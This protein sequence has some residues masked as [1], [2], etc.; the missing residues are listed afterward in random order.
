MSPAWGD[1]RAVV[2]DIDGTL[3]DSADG[4][5]AGYVHALESVGVT[6]PDDDTL[7]SDL[8]PPI[9][10]LLPSL[11]VPAERLDEA[12]TAYRTF[13]LREGLQRAAEYDGVSQVL[14]SLS[15]AFP[16]GTATAKRTDVALAIL[17]SHGL[18]GFFTVVN[19]L[20]DDHPTKA[21]TLTQTL[22]L[23]GELDPATTVMVGDRRSDIVAGRAVG[24]WTI[25]VLWGYGSRA[26][27]EGAGADVLLEHPHQLVDLLLS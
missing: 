18:A 15:R 26:E 16:L 24:T 1:L 3:L 11:G 22:G 25:G 9:V 8:G 14:T 7:R 17:E 13:Y 21:A 27:L 23:M 20:G 5:V 19:G 12:L 6:A 10:T 2:L 4:I